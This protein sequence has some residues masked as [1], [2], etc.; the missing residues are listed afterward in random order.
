MLAFGYQRRQIGKHG[1]GIR[2]IMVMMR[3]RDRLSQHPGCD[4]PVKHHGGNISMICGHLADAAHPVFGCDFDKTDI[5]RGKC[6]EF[7]DIHCDL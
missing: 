6:F 5:T 1:T 7:L 4:L 3:R 2:T